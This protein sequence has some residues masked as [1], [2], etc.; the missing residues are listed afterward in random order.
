MS[1][2][3]CDRWVQTLNNMGYM[4]LSFDPFS[5]KFLE[6]CEKNVGLHVFE[7]GAAYG[8]MTHLA[9]QSGA[10]VTANDS[11]QKHLDLLY[12]N[13]P[14]E[15]IHALKLATGV[16]P[17]EIDFPSSTYDAIYSSRML[18]FLTGDEL[19]TCIGKF[20]KW[21]KEGGRMFI[22]T[23]TPYLG[24]YSSFIPTYEERKRQGHLWPGLIE[25]TS[26]FKSIRYNNIPHLLNFFD[27][28]ILRRTAEKTGFIVQ[29]C[30]FINRDD[31]PPELRHDGR[32]SVG[33]IALKP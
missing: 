23:E 14:K 10:F 21:L 16:L 17:H 7:G 8:I 1:D 27:P 20:F 12:K 9:L 19:E 33:L 25:D 15:H 26:E 11:E 28:D 32:E 3:K 22:I 31:F 5:K 18:H 30:A 2:I 4:S 24:C 13:T 29:E 6:H